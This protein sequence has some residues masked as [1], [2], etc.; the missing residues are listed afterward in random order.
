VVRIALIFV[1]LC[2]G[3]AVLSAQSGNIRVGS[4]T[5]PGATVTVSQGSQHYSTVTDADGH[6][7]ISVPTGEWT[8]EVSMFGFEPLKQVVRL[9]PG[10]PVN[11]QLKLAESPL[12]ARLK[13]FA[14][15]Q[16]GGELALGPNLGNQG[17]ISPQAELQNALNGQT[18]AQFSSE[19][20]TNG[21]NESFLV[22]GSLSQGMAQNA[23]P[24]TNGFGIPG[25]GGFG[26]GQEGISA[27]QSGSGLN[28]TASGFTQNASTADAGANGAGGGGF[29]PGGG[30]GGFGGG[31]GGFG[32]GGMG[33][34]GFGG[35]PDG[36]PRNREGGFRATAFGNR[37]RPNQIH[38]MLSFQLGNSA[39]DAKPFSVTGQEVS[40][41]AYAQSR[42]SALV[43][44][45][46]VI[47][48]LLKDPSTFF[49]FSYFGTRNKTP[50][51]FTETVPTDLERTGNF[52]ESVRSGGAV[53]I[54]NPSPRQPF[55]GNIIPTSLLN[56]ISLGLLSYFPQPNQPGLVNNYQYVVSS[57]QNTDNLGFRIQRN[58]NSQNRLSY[59]LNVQ[60]RNSQSPQ[61]FGF[62]DPV[63]GFGLRTSLAW[64]YNITPTAIN[65]LQ[66][67]FNRNRNETLPFFA[68]GSNVAAGLGIQGTSSN[69]LNYG[70]PNLSF[71]NFGALSDSSY[72]LTRNQ[73]EALADGVVLNRGQHT[74]RFGLQ[75]Q[76]NDLAT[77]TDQNGR[78]TYTFTGT[79]T[80]AIGANGQPV[81]GT[82]FDFADYLLGLPES[83]SITYGNSSLYFNENVWSGYVQDDWRIHP[84]FTLLVGV[85]YEYFQPFTEKYGVLTNLD[86]APGYTGVGLVTPQSPIGP[87][88][89]AFPAGLINSDYN[90]FGPRVGFAWRVPGIKRSTVVRGGFGIYY[91]GQAYYQFPL[92]LAQQPPFAVSNN[93]V[94]NIANPLT[95]ADGFLG[96][97]PGKNLLNTYAVNRD[98]RTPYAQT[99]TLSIQHELT[100]GMFVEGTYVG[101]KGTGLDVYLS[102]NSAPPG[103]PLDSEN[104]LPI[105]NA[106]TFTYD[107]PVGNS[108][109]NG[110]LLRFSQR[111]NHGISFRATYTLSK[112]IDDVS[113]FTG[114]G[115]GTVVQNYRDI[116]A[117]RGLSA[118]DHRQV[119]DMNWVLTSRY[120]ENEDTLMARL[121]KNW[122]V[123]GGITAETG[124]PLTASVLGN[125]ANIAGSGNVGSGRAEATGQSIAASGGFFNPGAFTTPPSG[126]YGNAGR[127]T[128]PGPG[129]FSLNASFGRSFQFGETRRRLEFRIEGNNVL[130]NVNYT[131]VNT[132]V[133][134]TNY[135]LATAAGTMRQLDA[136]VRFRF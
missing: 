55:P 51:T 22:G 33:G 67:T 71:T 81:A 27:A 116:A 11:L 107:T 74:I 41:P 60:N 19:G 44:G 16:N 46:L 84:R 64:T 56:P 45:P 93:V 53:Q 106:T 78:G 87:Y 65:N 12:A 62:E 128:I 28:G 52:S 135:G 80:S 76:R 24:D 61:A 109:Y 70:P 130:N 21:G 58:I 126:Q 102:P 39:V 47:P 20:G 10:A 90:N 5:I 132:V 112:S 122:T 98:Y 40:Q 36:G 110:V 43:G 1:L 69:P 111:F 133:N 8:I 113:T 18:P 13:Q 100:R 99:W 120:R 79:L 59:Q 75:Y 92:R 50:N 68:N 2:G 49:F 131:S 15:R 125:Q 66:F 38:G 94:S 42:F 82:G 31:G 35:G 14:A 6:F 118:F 23:R 101:T 9:A 25:P 48:K 34:R 117:E 85:R 37:R 7:F 136:V 83:A 95:V 124:S 115:V 97:I 29:G 73:S 114:P 63:N 91:N 104:R 30:P 77:Q 121:L 17:A 89:G 86:V 96:A 123:S 3:G 105:A 119:F 57:A 32:G 54:F 134:A 4:Q 26:P 129:L 108:S 88:S 72:T 103:T 127:N